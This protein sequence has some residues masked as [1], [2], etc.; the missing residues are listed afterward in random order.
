MKK[1][2]SVF[3]I[4]CVMIN[5]IS[6]GQNSNLGNIELSS[7]LS[8]EEQSLQ[9]NNYGSIEEYTF[10]VEN[11]SLPNY[12][13]S[14]YLSADPLTTLT[15]SEDQRSMT[16]NTDFGY[17][18]IPIGK[19]DII[20]PIFSGIP[21]ISVENKINEE[22]A[23]FISEIKICPDGNSIHNGWINGNLTFKVSYYNARILNVLLM[24]DEIHEEPEGRFFEGAVSFL[25]DLQTGERLR[26]K[27]FFEISSESFETYFNS[28]FFYSMG[29]KYIESS[30]DVSE[31]M[32]DSGVSALKSILKYRDNRIEFDEPNA[33]IDQA[34]ATSFLLKEDSEIYLYL[35]F[36]VE[37][38]EFIWFRSP[39]DALEGY[40]Y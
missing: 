30:T 34:T 25:Y 28:N 36:S 16:M 12:K 21:N 22:I 26:L 39:L 20:Y 37:N 33:I 8:Y 13:L 9:P 32:K 14:E 27:N 11:N 23:T 29:S 1:R 17:T 15:W 10:S 38:T 4:L 24:A 19:V 7:E 6:C 2:I 40:Y 5:L 31:K 18:S 3:L 35:G